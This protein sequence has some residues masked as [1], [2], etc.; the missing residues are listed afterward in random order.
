MPSTHPGEAARLYWPRIVLQP[1]VGVYRF[2]LLPFRRTSLADA[3]GGTTSET[4][5]P[6]GLIASSAL[7]CIRFTSA[8]PASENVGLADSFRP[9]SVG[10]GLWCSLAIIWGLASAGRRNTAWFLRDSGYNVDY[11]DKYARRGDPELRIYGLLIVPATRDG[12]A[13]AA[14]WA[15]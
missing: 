13:N 3:H 11:G 9:V 6:I 7:A 2:P 5:M 4:Q 12:K 15:A 10:P 8:P 1:A 14:R